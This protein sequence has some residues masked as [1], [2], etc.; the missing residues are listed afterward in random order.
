MNL[1]ILDL[2]RAHEMTSAGVTLDPGTTV[3]YAL[4]VSPHFSSATPTTEASMM[5]G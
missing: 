2:L 4:G 3:I 1:L 5:S